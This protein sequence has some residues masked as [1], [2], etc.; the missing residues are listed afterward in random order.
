MLSFFS[1]ISIHWESICSQHD[2][3]TAVNLTNSP[4]RLRHLA[5][6]EVIP[7]EAKVIPHET[8]TPIAGTISMVPWPVVLTSRK[9]Y[10]N[11]THQQQTPFKH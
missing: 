9:H 6:A 4:R 5:S 10:W 11:Y 1:G 7:Y 2:K 3:P 8:I